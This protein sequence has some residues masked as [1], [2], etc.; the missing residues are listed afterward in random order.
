MALVHFI[1]QAKT[2]DIPIWLLDYWPLFFKSIHFIPSICLVYMA[3]D[4]Y[5]FL[6]MGL[7]VQ[8]VFGGA[9]GTISVLDGWKFFDYLLSILFLDLCWY[10]NLFLLLCED[11][12]HISVGI[13][14]IFLPLHICWHLLLAPFSLKCFVDQSRGFGY[15]FLVAI[16]FI[17]YWRLVPIW[18]YL[19]Q[20]L[21]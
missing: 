8:L 18:W 11:W 4:K 7:F 14:F 13:F 2:C 1:S 12:R 15:C 10:Q 19:W 6:L 17:D 20:H 16:L 9:Y 3:E 5:E 21:L